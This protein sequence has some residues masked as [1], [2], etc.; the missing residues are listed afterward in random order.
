LP[1]T[2]SGK[3]VELAVREVRH[4]RRVKNTGALADSESLDF[5]REHPELSTPHMK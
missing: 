5:F 3:L 2:R 1:H 4:G